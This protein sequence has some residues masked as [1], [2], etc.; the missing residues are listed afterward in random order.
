MVCF[1]VKELKFKVDGFVQLN[2]IIR[3]DTKERDDLA[4]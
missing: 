4:Y 1:E 3:D 2:P